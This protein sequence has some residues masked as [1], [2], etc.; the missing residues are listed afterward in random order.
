[1]VSMVMVGNVPGQGSFFCED[2]AATM[3]TRCCWCSISKWPSHGSH[4]MDCGSLKE[5]LFC[6]FLV[7]VFFFFSS[8]CA[9]CTFSGG[10]VVVPGEFL[11]Q[12]ETFD[13]LLIKCCHGYL[14]L[15]ETFHA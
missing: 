7:R 2:G 10:C 9:V 11:C 8:G 4:H 3:L 14:H 13:F 12:A 1:M 15:Q 6:L 5:H